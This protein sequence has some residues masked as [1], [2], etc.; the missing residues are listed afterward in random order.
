MTSSISVNPWLGPVVSGWLR[1]LHPY[2][3]PYFD[4]QLEEKLNEFLTLD[5]FITSVDLITDAF[6]NSGEPDTPENIPLSK[7]NANLNS[8]SNQSRSSTAEESR[9]VNLSFR[10][11]Q[12]NIVKAFLKSFLDVFISKIISLDKFLSSFSTNRD[13][14]FLF[15]V[16]VLDLLVS[17][18]FNCE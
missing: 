8:N 15:F 11:S 10:E 18:L 6:I 17:E 9:N 5:L 16:D 13:Y 7:D 3:K 4:A 1:F 2:L 12:A 14:I